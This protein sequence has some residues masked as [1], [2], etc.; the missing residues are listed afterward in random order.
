MRQVALQPDAAVRGAVLALV[1]LVVL[2]HAAL[3]DRDQ[4]LLEERGVVS[5]GVVTELRSPWRRAAVQV[6]WTLPSGHRALV[7]TSRFPQHLGL[8]VGDEFDLVHDPQ[9]PRRMQHVDF[10]VDPWLRLLRYGGGGLG[11]LVGLV[12]VV[13]NLLRQV[14]SVQRSWRRGV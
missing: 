13:R 2:V 5:T 12:P 14:L 10:V 3:V 6:T 9:R 11:V 8:E 4:R 1:C 7:T